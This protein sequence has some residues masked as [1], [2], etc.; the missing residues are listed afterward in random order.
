MAEDKIKIYGE[1]ESG[2]P[3]GVVM[4]LKKSVT[5]EELLNLRNHSRLQ[6]GMQYR[7]TD[8]ETVCKDTVE[9]ISAGNVF[10]IVVTADSS[11]TLKEEASVMHREGDIYFAHCNLAA[12]KIKYC[13]D[14]DTSRF[15]WVPGDE[16]EAA[17]FDGYAYQRKP[18]ED[19]TIGNYTYIAWYNANNTSAPLVY[20]LS[21]DPK[22]DRCVAFFWDSLYSEMVGEATFGLYREAVRHAK[23]V[24]YWMRD[25][26]G[27][28]CPYDF[29]NLKFSYSKFPHKNLNVTIADYTYTFATNDGSSRDFTVLPE[30]MVKNNVIKSNN[31]GE[32]AFNLIFGNSSGNFFDADCNYN[33]ILDSCGNKF[34]QSC[35]FEILYSGCCFNV[36]EHGSNNVELHL[37]C[38]SNIFKSN[39]GNITLYDF[40]DSNVFENNCFNIALGQMS[41]RNFFGIASSDISLGKNCYDNYYGNGVQNVRMF[42]G[43][44]KTSTPQPLDYVSNCHFENYTRNFIS[45]FQCDPNKGDYLRNVYVRTGD[46]LKNIFDNTIP[47]NASRITIYIGDN[48]E[49]IV[50]NG[51]RDFLPSP[52][53][54]I[55][56][57]YQI[58]VSSPDD[59]IKWIKLDDIAKL[60]ISS[61]KNVELFDGFVD[62]AGANFMASSTG[63]NITG[64]FYLK[65]KG[66]FGGKTSGEKYFSNWTAMQSVGADYN[67]ITAENPNQTVPR[68]D[69]I[70]ENVKDGCR[71]YW[72][73]SNLVEY[74]K[75]S[76]SYSEPTT[77]GS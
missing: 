29:K 15:N 35:R 48:E 70:F 28:E 39:S 53:S 60:V 1:L 10:D 18:E 57:T 71:Y 76:W 62:E 54:K 21:T 58:L 45:F 36:F 11:S 8:Y 67:V 50:V 73:G 69:R 20:S 12:W 56:D 49:Y 55:E 52:D 7:I 64:V 6:P 2:V 44:A 3:G 43:T 5:Y 72:N 41:Q 33:V 32:L 46:Y 77:P 26:H 31:L 25:E 24:I 9:Y 47:L 63:S 42:L 75:D 37:G 13:L 30:S 22:P 40:C 4:S 16:A 34:G 38:C 17:M 65:D 61:Y 23:G 14:N 19:K 59:Y 66:C 27:N 74:D 68:S 51:T